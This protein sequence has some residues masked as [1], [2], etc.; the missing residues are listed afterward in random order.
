[1]GFFRK[2]H[3]EKRRTQKREE[4]AKLQP[5]VEQNALDS[6]KEAEMIERQHKEQE[7]AFH[8]QQVEHERLMQEIAEK[9]DQQLTGN[10]EDFLRK[11]KQPGG[12]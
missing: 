12:Q 3:Q 7:A 6:Q 4:N 8:A 2:Q 9:V 5:R 11:V 1:M 10:S